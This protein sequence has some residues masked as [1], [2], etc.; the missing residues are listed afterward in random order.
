MRVGYEWSKADVMGL[1][2]EYITGLMNNES[3]M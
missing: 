3:D 1:D 2:E